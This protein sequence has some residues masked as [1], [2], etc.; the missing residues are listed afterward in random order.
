MALTTTLYDRMVAGLYDHHDLCVPV[1]PEVVVAVYAGDVYIENGY[2]FA[3]LDKMPSCVWDESI[4]DFR[5]PT[6][7]E[8][9][10][11][12]RWWIE[13]Y[14]CEGDLYL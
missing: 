10:D 4:W 7:R 8:Y 3:D 9:F 5:T 11:G 6:G 13:Y 12:A 2:V 1:T 14:A